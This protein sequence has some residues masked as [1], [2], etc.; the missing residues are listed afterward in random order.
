MTALCLAIA[1][2]CGRSSEAQSKPDVAEQTIPVRVAYP[3]RRDMQDRLPLTATVE[4]DIAVEIFAK[5]TGRCIAIHAETGDHVEAGSK[6]VSLDD[7]EAKVTAKQAKVRLQKAKADLDRSQAMRDQSL[8]SAE[9]FQ[10]SRLAFEE[11]EAGYELARITVADASISAPVG[12][13]IVERFCKIGDLITPTTPLMRVI[14]FSTLEAVVHVPEHVLPRLRVGLPAMIT[15]DAVPGTEIAAEVSEISPVVNPASGTIAVTV[16]LPEDTQLRPGMFV[17]VALVL[18]ERTDA[19]V[20]PTVALMAE[21][22]AYS[23]FCV[24]DSR[25]ER[26]AVTTGLRD[27]AWVE[28]FGDVSAGDAVVTEGLFRL[29]QGTTVRIVESPPT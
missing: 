23:V 29:E 20:L 6:L 12:G 11:A 26:V 14:D 2:G 21:G 22:G 10:S 9:L 7:E 5:T 18:E 16:G 28:V 27:G 19:L 4:A 13:M 25:A 3:E 8:L 1:S 24:R 17:R 15:A